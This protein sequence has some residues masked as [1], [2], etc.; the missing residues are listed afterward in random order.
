MSLV[1][2]VQDDSNYCTSLLILPTELLVMILSY[3]SIR[4]IISMLYV[5]QRFKEVSETSS[6]WKKFVWPDCEPYEP[7]KPYDVDSKYYEN[8][9]GMYFDK[10]YTSAYILEEV[11]YCP[12]LEH[13]ILTRNIQL[14][15]DHLEEI[16]HTLPHL[17]ELDVFA[18]SI[19][20]DPSYHVHVIKLLEA[21]ASVRRLLLKLDWPFYSVVR[22][23]LC[24]LE[25]L[26]KK[27]HPLPSVINLFIYKDDVRASISIL[28]SWPASS[29]TIASLEIGLYDIARVPMGLHFIP[30]R[31]FQ[32]GPAA[33]PFLIKL[34]DHG[35]LGLDRDIFYLSD[36]G[37]VSYL[38][39]SPKYTDL[40]AVKD[41]HLHCIS[42]FDSVL[43][44]DFSSVNIY[45]DHLEQLAIACPNLEQLNLK[46]AQNCL[47]SLQG[48]R[49]IVDTCQNLRGLNLIGIPVS[50][51]ESYL[52]LWELLSSIK[53]FTHL[54]IDLC[55][56]IQSS[57]S[58][59]DKDK[60]IGMLGKCDSLEALEIIQTF[61]CDECQNI[62]SVN[63]LLFS[64]FPS[65]VYVRLSHVQCTTAFEY[66]ITNCRWL[67]HLYYG[68]DLCSEAHVTLPSSS[69][70]HLEQLCV[71]S[72]AINLSASSVQVLSAHGELE[73]V[74]LFVK[75]IT[76]SAITTLISNSP[77]LMLL[78]I[79]S[80]EPLCDDDGASVDQEDYKDTISK[81][82]SHHK[83]MTTGDLVLTESCYWHPLSKMLD[84]NFN[85]LW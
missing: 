38:S 60:L 9:I 62:S 67:K 41:E 45:P 7:Y 17:E 74:A 80:R 20:W 36:Y 49:A 47:Q 66:I 78:Y 69:G 33:K 15:L 26:L 52:L 58:A 63:D 55:M 56:L 44:V 21:T 59:A 53:K 72:C 73:K 4:D 10:R 37:Y 46:N 28:E 75:S 48:L 64:H 34:S 23:F 2:D 54:A 39:V 65:L 83:F 30:L 42:N 24:T 8:V 16:V 5:S 43:N 57:D 19:K 81:R 32:F 11:H 76:T 84:T 50:S 77:N 85:S 13:V 3:L 68:T 12:N 27:G 6:L 40:Y 79:V 70:C 29:Y 25:I 82:F 14:S 1:M 51:M 35:I 31:K 22:E 61:N 71:K 18:S